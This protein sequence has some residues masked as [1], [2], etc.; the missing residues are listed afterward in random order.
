MCESV[1]AFEFL[2]GPAIGFDEEASGEFSDGI[3]QGAPAHF[4]NAIESEIGG[5]A[6]FGIGGGIEGDGGAAGD[7]ARGLE[8]AN[9]GAG[10]WWECVEESVVDGDTVGIELE[11]ERGRMEGIVDGT[12]SGEDLSADD[13]GEIEGDLFGPPM[14]GASEVFDEVGEFGGLYGD[15]EALEIEFEFDLVVGFVS[16]GEDIEA[17][18]T[19]RGAAWGEEGVPDGQEFGRDASCDALIEFEFECLEFELEGSCFWVCDIERR[20][21]EDA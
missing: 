10:F 6:G 19:E 9:D 4:A 20:A 8:I 21:L 13:G 7:G 12:F 11:G 15:V 2:E 3:W 18:A 14:D 16:C 5:D 17:D 1:F